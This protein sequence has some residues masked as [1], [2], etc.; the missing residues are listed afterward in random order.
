MYSWY[1][2]ISEG[3]KTRLIWNEQTSLAGCNNGEIAKELRK[4]LTSK[5][6]APFGWTIPIAEKWNSHGYSLIIDMKPKTKEVF[7]CE[8]DRVF[9]YC[10]H[11][12]SP[13][14]LRLKLI[15]GDVHDNSIDKRN[16][17]L[18]D[19]LTIIYT[20]YYLYGSVHKG[21]LTGKWIPPYGTVTALLFWPEAM[22]FFYDQVE[23]FDPNFLNSK[24]KLMA[25][26]DQ[27]T[28]TATRA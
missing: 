28:P 19:K 20:M 17:I 1:Q 16:F 12:W 10:Y 22:T 26:W 15:F 13:I 2:R 7:L 24:T 25:M 14:M 8:V 5:D 27:N 6:T 23:N 11:G 21:K 3:D 18:P 9:G 4:I